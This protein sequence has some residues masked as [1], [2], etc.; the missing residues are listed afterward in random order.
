[1]KVVISSPMGCLNPET[2]IVHLLANYLRTVATEVT[3]LKCNGIFSICD[4]DVENGWRR[5]IDSCIGC[6]QEQGQLAAWSGA[7]TVDLSKFL[8]PSD[9]E[10]T[11]RWILAIGATELHQAKFEDQRLFDLCGHLF[12]ARFSTDLPV[13][14]NR[15][16]D[17][18]L[19]RLYLSQARMI[20]AARRFLFSYQPKLLFVSGERDSISK[21]LGLEAEKLALRTVRF[22]WHPQERVIKITLPDSGKSVACEI[23][24]TN[25]LALR[26][27]SRTWPLEMVTALEDILDALGLSRG[28]ILAP[29][30][31]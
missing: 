12:R 13:A 28:T 30:A 25:L 7:N 11:R 17:Q 2:G 1:M 16:H 8:P 3:Q 5:S 29:V 26:N 31:R 21:A 22:H 19:R 27:D 15:Q 20:M 14:S 4:R 6:M 23:V 24:I 10:D 9:I 18:F